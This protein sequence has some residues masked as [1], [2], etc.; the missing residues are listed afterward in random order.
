MKKGKGKVQIAKGMSV[1]KST[2]SKMKKEPGG[3]NV[4]KYKDVKQS[5]MALKGHYPINTEKRARAALSYAHNANPAEQ[6][7]IKR[8]V[9]A[10]YPSIQVKGLKNKKK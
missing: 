9:K 10:K 3:S 7:T 8:K 2:A 5:D 4:G 1:S 6:A